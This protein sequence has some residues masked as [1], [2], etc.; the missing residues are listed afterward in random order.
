MAGVLASLSLDVLLASADPGVGRTGVDEQVVIRSWG[1]H[2][3]TSGI[4]DSSVSDREARDDTPLVGTSRLQVLSTRAIMLGQ[5]TTEVEAPDEG[6]SDMG[7][8]NF[9]DRRRRCGVRRDRDSEE[10]GSQK[11]SGA[12][13]D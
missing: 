11:R 10:K 6:Q 7:L 9:N 12:E 4:C 1:A 8:A 3:D 5:I 13:H 2:T